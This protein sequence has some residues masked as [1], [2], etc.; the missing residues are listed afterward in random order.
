MEPANSLDPILLRDWDIDEFHRRVLQ[1]EE[2]GYIARRETYK[3]L[4]EVNP[5]T[6]EVLHLHSIELFP[7]VV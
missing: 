1:F 5:E 3:I 7:P 4:A 6:G 2:R